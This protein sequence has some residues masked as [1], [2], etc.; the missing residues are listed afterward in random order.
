MKARGSGSDSDDAVVE[1]VPED[2][3]GNA[4]SPYQ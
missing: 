1:S 4:L 2:K 3:K